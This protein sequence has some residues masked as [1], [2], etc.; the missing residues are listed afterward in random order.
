MHHHKTVSVI[1]P[2]FNE[3]DSIGELVKQIRSH[4]SVDE[5][6]VVDDGSTD[7]TAERAEAA[8]AK[9]ARHPYNLGN[10]AAVKTGVRRATGEIVVLM[11]GD[12]QHHP[13]EIPKLLEPLTEFEMVVGARTHESDVSRFRTF[14]NVCMTWV[15]NYL[16]G[17][18]IQ[19][20][21]SGFRA[22]RREVLCEF[23]HLFP[24]K[25]S[26]PTTITLSLLKSGYAVKYVS[27]NSIQR[28]RKGKSHIQPF[29]DGLRFL[30]IIV[31]IVM[32]FDPLKIFMPASLFL[33][34]LGAGFTVFDL[35][36][37]GGLQE[38]AVL[39]LL[40]GIFVFFFGFLADQN[41]H[42]RRELK[43]SSRTAE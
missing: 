31:R 26:Y 30:L 36:R 37:Y 28:R 18:K 35:L 7:K 9:V 21:T 1:L 22:I 24:N 34:A 12:G 3:E 32:L 15:A 14:G 6:W 11:D 27:L 2:C 33:I 39:T 40:I 4:S 10:G 16:S 5:V 43:S 25:Y 38:S 20:L 42:I 19:D 41:A 23:L 17:T 8:G 29:G 13:E